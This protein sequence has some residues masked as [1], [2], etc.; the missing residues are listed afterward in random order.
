MRFHL[1]PRQDGKLQAR[2]GDALARH[3]A[4]ANL[5][6]RVQIVKLAHR[7]AGKRIELT[8]V[9]HLK[10]DDVP[11][12]LDDENADPWSVYGSFSTELPEDDAA[13]YLR[14]LTPLTKEIFDG[15]AAQYKSDAFT[16]AGAA[17]IRL[18]EKIRD[19]LADVAQKGKTAQDFEAAVKQLTDDAGVAEL[20]S[21]TLD[22]A[23]STAM[24]KAYSLGRYE[25]MKD[26]AVQEVFPFWQYW[27]VGDDRVRPEHEVLDGFAARAHDPVWKK[28][29]PPKDAEE[30]GYLRLPLLA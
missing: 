22:T 23:F 6:G 15:L 1:M 12:A 5:L 30:P 2:V 27:T 16:L 25:Q 26:P 19:A 11:D 13:G 10:F 20:N 17:D 9:S 28:I 18:I 3:L 29:Y 24:Q 21:F 14:A 8:G 4:A 7:R